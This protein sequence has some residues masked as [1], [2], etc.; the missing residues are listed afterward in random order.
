MR[1]LRLYLRNPA[2]I[3]GLVLLAAVLFLAAS[4]DLFYAATR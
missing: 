2:A 1:F 4:A 3:I